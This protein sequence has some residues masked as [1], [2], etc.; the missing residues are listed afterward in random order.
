MPAGISML[1]HLLGDFH[2]PLQGSASLR[3][4]L[5]K[6]K[7][8]LKGEFKLNMFP[9]ADPTKNVEKHRKFLEKIIE[10]D[11]SLSNNTIAE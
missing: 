1:C 8:N 3:E 11:E 10:D 2:P 5:D 7:L 6:R 9:I 4:Y